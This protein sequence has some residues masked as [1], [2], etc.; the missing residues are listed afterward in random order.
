[1]QLLSTRELC[2]CRTR[3]SISYEIVQYRRDSPLALPL[4]VPLLRNIPYWSPTG[5]P[6]LALDG[7]SLITKRLGVRINPQTQT[8]RGEPSGP[9]GE[10]FGKS[11]YSIGDWKAETATIHGDLPESR[12][13][14]YRR[15]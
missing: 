3:K 5:I 14:R 12:V 6:T 2:L 10:G 15:S 9:V 11:P 1:M 13:M 7:K 8:P 4:T